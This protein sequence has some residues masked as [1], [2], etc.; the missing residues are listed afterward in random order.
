MVR[1]YLELVALHIRA[2]LIVSICP[3]VSL[4]L[5]ALGILEFLV[6]LISRNATLTAAI[7]CSNVKRVSGN[8]GVLKAIMA[9]KSLA[10]AMDLWNTLLIVILSH[11]AFALPTP[12]EYSGLRVHTFRSVMRTANTPPSNAKGVLVTAGVFLMMVLRSLVHAPLSIRLVW[13]ARLCPNV[14]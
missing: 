12:Q 14:C 6:M 8:V 5:N 2:S 7:L 11:H 9:T 1:K 13:I 4:L 3:L 10:L